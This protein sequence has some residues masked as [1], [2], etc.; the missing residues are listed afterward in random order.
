MG[1]IIVT[2]EIKREVIEYFRY[3]DDE[4][5]VQHYLNEVADDLFAF[6][7]YCKEQEMHPADA[8]RYAILNTMLGYDIGI[9]NFKKLDCYTY[10]HGHDILDFVVKDKDF[11]ECA[12]KE[13]HL[14]INFDKWKE[15]DYEY[16]EY[17]YYDDVRG[18]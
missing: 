2:D 10:E 13:L 7:Y 8:D 9:E 6:Y 5:L 16:Y 14:D 4:E 12:V 18:Y 3:E 1:K 11:I 17:H 15:E